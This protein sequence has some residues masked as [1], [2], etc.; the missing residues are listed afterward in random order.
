MSDDLSIFVGA[1]TNDND[2]FLLLKYGNRHGLIAGATGT[3][4]T[5]TL[6]T[7]AEGFAAFGVPVFMADV[8][9]DLA[10]IAQRGGD[11]PRIVERARQLKIDGFAG[12]AFPVVLWDLF[13]E[14]GHPVR[15]TVSEIGPLLMAR[16]LD[17]NPTQEGVLNIVFRIADEQ[18]LLLLD[19]KDLT[20]LL[21]WCGENAGQLTTQYGNVS[22]ASV[23]TIQRALLVL[24]QQGGEHFFGEPALD[25]HDMFRRDSSNVGYINVLAADRLMQNPRLYGTFLLWM[26]SEL[27]ESMP[28][29]GDLDRP[30]FVFFFDEAH[31]LFDDA[32][33]ALVEKI[34]QVVRLIR[35]KGVGVYFITQNPLDVPESV[36]GQLGNRVQ[37]ALRAFTPKDQ[38]A[39]KS[40]AQT[41]RAN[42]A[43][44]ATKA[45]LELGVGE[46]LVSFLDARG[47]PSPVERVFVAPPQSRLGPLSDA[48][49]NA[50]ARA[51]PIA[52]KYDQV[53]DRDSAF[54]V[55]MGRAQAQPAPAESGGTRRRGQYGAPPPPPPPLDSPPPS[56]SWGHGA[57]PAGE[58][59]PQR[60][61]PRLRHS[62]PPEEQPGPRGRA[63]AGSRSDSLGTTIVKSAAR[64]ATNIAVR[65]ATK[66]MIGGRGGGIAGSLLRG[67]LG[68]ILK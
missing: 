42:D 8:K 7:I 14:K 45:I 41:F 54:E 67:V 3:G 18:G 53:V 10:G 56:S 27:F 39:V 50:V 5:V 51:S 36:L 34:E 4:K 28:E 40:A 37:H 64:T 16:L 57:P 49:R 68:S 9:G 35:S 6:Q 30:K 55:L 13:G 19:F 22:K 24:E 1:G 58:P 12:R 48:E 11:N 46:A 62:L 38:K 61:Q 66:A 20:A 26:L 63:P 52:G 47:V 23:G 2:Q 59:P 31:L 17:L 15:T 44:D 29:V 65:E 32:P 21:Q 60:G 43:F 25:L 33:K